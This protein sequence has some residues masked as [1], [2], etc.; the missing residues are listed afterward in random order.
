MILNEPVRCTG[1][2][3]E[4]PKNL[5]QPKQMTKDKTGWN[6]DGDDSR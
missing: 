3:F 5:E 1:S 2:T 4:Q 6:D